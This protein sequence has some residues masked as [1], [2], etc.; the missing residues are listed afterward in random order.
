M[1]SDPIAVSEDFDLFDPNLK[2]PA[3]KP[4]IGPIYEP[5]PLPAP[6]MN[7]DYVRRL[8][9]QTAEGLALLERDFPNL[10]QDLETAWR[11]ADR[12]H[13]LGGFASRFVQELGRG[14]AEQIELQRE[15][16]FRHTIDGA[17]LGCIQVLLDNLR[18]V[19][20]RLIAIEAA[21]GLPVGAA[22]PEPVE[23]ANP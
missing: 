5:P 14:K 7:P 3:D 21:A 23:E 6:K 8:L 11:T 2:L 18:D 19:R 15:A 9:L 13:E 20:T 10:R 17:I 16:K 22:P 4:K 1:S 12:A